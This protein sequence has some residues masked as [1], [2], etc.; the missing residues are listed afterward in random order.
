MKLPDRCQFELGF[1]GNR[2]NESPPVAGD[3]RVVIFLRPAKIEVADAISRR[4]PA[5]PRAEARPQPLQLFPAGY[6]DDPGSACAPALRGRG[7]RTAR[8]FDPFAV[9]PGSGSSLPIAVRQANP[10][11]YRIHRA[12]RFGALQ[13]IP[14]KAILP[15][16]WGLKILSPLSS[17]LIRGFGEGV[18]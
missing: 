17:G 16:T 13:P 2:L 8:L 14:H 12:D 3:D 10:R 4:R 6:A 11:Q 15:A 1:A 7:F 18:Y 5:L 9:L